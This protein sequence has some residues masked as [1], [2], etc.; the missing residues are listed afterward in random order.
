MRTELLLVTPEMANSFLAASAA[1][2]QAAEDN[3]VVLK[4]RNFRPRWS[5]E[6]ARRITAGEWD[7][8][9]Q[10]IALSSSGFILDGQH[11][12]PAIV[13]A[14]IPVLMNVT[15]DV[16]DSAFSQIDGG[17]PR[18]LADRSSLPV[19]L[20]Q[21]ARLAVSIIYGGGVARNSAPV[22]QALAA[23]G[24]ADAYEYLFAG[25]SHTKTFSSA[26]MRLMMCVLVIDGRDAAYIRTVYKN[27]TTHN[28]NELPPIGNAFC[29]QVA[30]KGENWAINDKYG[31]MARAI[32]VFDKNQAD[33]TRLLVSESEKEAAT[34]YVKRVIKP[35]Y[36][37]QLKNKQLQ[38]Q[39]Q[40]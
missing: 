31:L 24:L 19:R 18:S 14:G 32:K 29:Q 8:T 1:A 34:R 27:L 20:V 30:I 6:I 21:V 25:T 28:Y 23:T 9:H 33:K 16:P 39:R 38:Q 22:M 2:E 13:A 11:R 37:Q 17:E 35:R 40:A 12:L 15:F 3:G 36:E 10:G 7:T 26:P 4:N 5:E